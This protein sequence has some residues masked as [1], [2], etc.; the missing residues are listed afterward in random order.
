[1][2]CMKLVVRKPCRPLA[3]RQQLKGIK[4][5]KKWTEN[6]VLTKA[7]LGYLGDVGGWAADAQPHV[8]FGTSA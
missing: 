1:M 2:I 6:H 4:E 3:V 5:E 8:D 7:R